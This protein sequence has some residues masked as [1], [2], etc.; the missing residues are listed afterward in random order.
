MQLLLYTNKTHQQEQEQE[1][2]SGRHHIP[3]T[4]EVLSCLFCGA[5]EGLALK[6]LPHQFLLSPSGVPVS[7]TLHFL[8]LMRGKW[9]RR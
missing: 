6:H 8:I 7:A 9:Q 2:N 1:A 5:R 4:V 3:A